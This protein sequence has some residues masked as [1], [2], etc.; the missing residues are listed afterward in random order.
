MRKRA[1]AQGEPVSPMLALLALGIFANVLLLDLGAIVA[2]FSFFGLAAFW[3][4]AAGLLAALPAAVRAVLDVLA[5]PGNPFRSAVTRHGLADIVMVGLLGIVWLGRL[6]GERTGNG[7]YLAVE[8]LAFAVGIAGAWSARGL[9]YA[10]DEPDAA[11][12]PSP[13]VA[14]GKGL[15]TLDTVRLTWPPRVVTTAAAK[16]TPDTSPKAAA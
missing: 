15:T 14:S 2:D 1:R 8:A 11:D 10:V 6:V 4:M 16:G 9:V 12:A 13:S 5:A 7:W 3:T